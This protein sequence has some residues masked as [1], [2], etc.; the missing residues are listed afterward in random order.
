MPVNDTPLNPDQ[1]SQFAVEFDGIQKAH[2]VKCSAFKETVAVIKYREGG[3]HFHR[4]IPSGNVEFDDITL[5]HGWSKN[6][7]FYDW[8]KAVYDAFKNG[9]VNETDP[10]LYKNFS[11]VQYDRDGKTELKRINCFR[12]FITVREVGDWDAN[13]DEVTMEKITVTFEQGDEA[14]S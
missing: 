4:K 3:G 2:F 7:E 12:A 1:K 10:T 11:I 5:E 8:S 9:G 14:F 13:A 6:R